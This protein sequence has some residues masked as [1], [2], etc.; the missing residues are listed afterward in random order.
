M[1]C[2][3]TPPPTPLTQQVAYLYTKVRTEF[4]K[5]CNFK[6]V[7]AQVGARWCPRAPSHHSDRAG[8]AV[9]TA[10]PTHGARVA[11]D[12]QIF[13]E[14]PCSDSNSI[15]PHRHRHTHMPLSHDDHRF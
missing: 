1:C 10:N 13:V 8:P 2:K 5:H 14:E 4:G 11:R 3:R 12:D 6:D 9:A 15:H 7:E